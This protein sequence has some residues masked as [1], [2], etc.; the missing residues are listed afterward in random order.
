MNLLIKNASVM[1]V[2]KDSEY[3]ADIYIKDGFF[4]K[5]ES[6][7]NV[8]DIEKDGAFNIIDAEGQTAIPGLIDAHTHVELSMLSSSSFAEALLANGTTAAVLDPHDAV[9]VL[10]HK[11]AKYLMEEMAETDL[12]P[13]WMASPCVPSAPGYE[14]CYG[15]IMLSDV[16]TMIEEYD[17]YGIAE[18]MDYN[19]V[20]SGEE[21][22]AEILSYG[23]ENNL[24]I[25]GHA[26]CVRGDDLNTYIKAGISSDHESV[27][28]EEQLEKFNKGMYVIIRRGSLKEPANAADLL[29]LTG[30]SPRILLSTDGCITAKDMLEHGHMNYAVAQLVE[31][32]VSPLQAVKMASLY[33]AKAY[34]LEKYGAIAK[35][36]KADLALIKDKKDFKVSKVIINGK[37][38]PTSYPRSS[39]PKEVINSIHHRLLT[40]EDIS[41]P[42]PIKDG[43]VKV[44]I[45][46]ITDG[47]LATVHETRILSVSDNHLILDDDL[48]YCAV[49]DRYRENGSIGVGI[50]S[51]AGA[52][53]GALAGSIAQD[54]QNLIAFG[55]SFSD[56]IYALNMVIKKQGG[57]SFVRKEKEEFFLALP[58][59][60]ILS[61]EPIESFVKE[62]DKLIE[63]IKKHG[64]IL[65]N[66][67]LTMSLQIPLA[68]I[69]EMAIT[70]R[71][72][73]D[74]SNQI[75]IPVC[76]PV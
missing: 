48:M 65:N 20:I 70:N 43:H 67:L 30:D 10:G 76:E 69:P 3:S 68:V 22:L 33:P 54:T 60:G 59:L 47:T 42:L 45:M 2:I 55:N 24:K 38:V 50:I 72:L 13:V 15:Q 49:I 40:A 39:F 18:A 34:G 73:L 46:Q 62:S 31:E 66:P 71:G 36:Y 17:M 41:I 4:E 29:K 5:I 56:I 11:G 64:C 27:T 12:T 63:E 21:S 19:R 51:N 25:D 8:E 52:L 57:V 61:Q 44:N 6:D 28:V 58:V 37:N 74:I 75:F 16:K 7:I 9:N 32:G 53:D 35:G 1:D 14:D 23:R 26:P